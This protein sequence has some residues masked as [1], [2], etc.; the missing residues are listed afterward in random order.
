MTNQ[1]SS[2]ILLIPSTGPFNHPNWFNSP[3]CLAGNSAK[4]H[5]K[6]SRNFTEV[7]GYIGCRTT[8]SITGGGGAERSWADCKELKSGKRSKIGS[9]KLMKQAALYT[10]SN[11]RRARIKRAELEKT[12]CTSKEARWGDEDEHFDLGLEKWGV[13]IDA[14]KQA[15]VPRRLLRCWI[16]SWENTMENTPVMRQKLLAKYGGLVFDDIDVTPPVRM[17]VSSTKIKFI[18]YQGWHVMAEPLEYS[19]DAGDLLLE[20]IKISNE[21]LIELLKNTEQPSI[22]N[23][24]MV[25]IPADEEEVESGEDS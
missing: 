12:D 3:D 13:D 16:E 15:A 23:V 17:T 10:S 2:W 9:D 1:S 4:W 18:K 5:D 24:C 25:K 22:L 19:G 6:Y 21:V 14:L 20:P 7:F 11:L 8:S